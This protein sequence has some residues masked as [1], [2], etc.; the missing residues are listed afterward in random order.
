MEEHIDAIT[1]AEL[2]EEELELLKEQH[3]HLVAK[4]TASA[5]LA[6]DSL[7][8]VIN[9]FRVRLGL[10]DSVDLEDLYGSGP[11]GTLH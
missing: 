9:Y 4:N 5:A 6:A 8:H 2:Y 3:A 1:I 11:S 10:E 7:T